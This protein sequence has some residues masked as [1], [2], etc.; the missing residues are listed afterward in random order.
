MPGRS[1]VGANGYK[2]GFNGKEKDDEV[3]GNGNSYDFGARIYD[4]RLGRWLSLDPLQARYPSISPYAYCANNPIAAID[5]DGR[6]VV[7]VV[8]VSYN[9]PANPAN[10]GDIGNATNTYKFTFNKTTNE[11]DIFVNT[12]IEYSSAFNNPGANGK[13]LE[14]ENPGLG[15]AVQTHEE[16]HKNRFVAAAEASYTFESTSLNGEKFEGRA[17]EIATQ[18]RTAHKKQTNTLFKSA[19]SAIESEYAPLLEKAKGK[20]YDKIA[21]EKDQK[22]LNTRTDIAKN[23]N[24]VFETELK[25]L[26]NLV[27]T[28]ELCLQSHDGPTGVNQTALDKMPASSKPY[29]DNTKPIKSQGKVVPKSPNH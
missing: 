16:E 20:L 11:Y 10:E 22:I 12:M 29:Q 25:T 7:P 6:A 24:T 5:P 19:I 27:A 26:L 9:G 2:Y 8:T 18:L 23:E 13:T 21:A 1:L 15:L 17:D 28:E 4:T 3:S 14:Q